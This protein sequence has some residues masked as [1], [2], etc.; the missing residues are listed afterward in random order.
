MATQID[1]EEIAQG[2]GYTILTRTL[3]SLKAFMKYYT[4]SIEE[5]VLTMFSEVVQDT[6]KRYKIDFDTDFSKFKP[7][8]FPTFSDVYATIKGRLLSTLVVVL[9]SILT[10]IIFF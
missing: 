9:L 4:P 10:T 8:D 1:E 7:E 3:Q 2:L 5:D 6:Y